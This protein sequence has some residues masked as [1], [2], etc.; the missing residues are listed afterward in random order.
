M[1]ELEG[2]KGRSN[3]TCTKLTH[4]QHLAYSGPRRGVQLHDG[5]Q[6]R[7]CVCVCVI[8]CVCV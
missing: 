3:H 1:G 8:V 5:R 4:L 2:C 7:L 6:E